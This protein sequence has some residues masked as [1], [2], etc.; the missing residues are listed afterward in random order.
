MFRSLVSNT[1]DCA[2]FLSHIY[3]ISVP[4]YPK[5]AFYALIKNNKIHIYNIY[6]QKG[7]ISYF[8]LQTKH[9]PNSLPAQ[10]YIPARKDLNSKP[11]ITI[12]NMKDA[13]VRHEKESS[14][15]MRGHGTGWERAES[16]TRLCLSSIDEQN[17]IKY[18][19]TY[20]RGSSRKSAKLAKP[21]PRI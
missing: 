4:C 21:L 2:K 5:H 7:D 6:H 3:D 9:S 13:F 14:D 11:G 8:H 16:R 15:S 12:S 1:G 19:N 10:K 17:K 20:R 18:T